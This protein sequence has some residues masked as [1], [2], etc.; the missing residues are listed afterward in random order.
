MMTSGETF[1]IAV[2]VDS[3]TRLDSG[4]VR[5]AEEMNSGETAVKYREASDAL[6]SSIYESIT[7]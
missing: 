7:K 6:A 4:G 2:N 3:E 1:K 5:V